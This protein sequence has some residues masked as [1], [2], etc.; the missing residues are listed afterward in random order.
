[1]KGTLGILAVL[2]ALLAAAAAAPAA[3]Q[4]KETYK[5][6]I[7]PV[8]KANRL[9]NE[10][11]MSGARQQIKRKMFVPVGKQFVRVSGSFGR[12]IRRLGPV[13]P[14]AGYER[15]VKRWLKFMRL[16]KLRLLKVGKL[17]KARQDIKAAHMSILAERAGISANNISIA[18]KVRECR[19][20]RVG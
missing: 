17:Y 15:T 8:C 12:L 4:T 14:P 16:I 13:P 3:E 11:I 19:F 7:E 1:M 18:F 10:R 6:R 5:E 20:G 9:A 2:V